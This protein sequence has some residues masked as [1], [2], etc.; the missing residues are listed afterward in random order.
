MSKRNRR[1]VKAA[2][3]KEREA[4]PLAEFRAIR[5]GACVCC[6]DYTHTY[7]PLRWCSRCLLEAS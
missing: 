1:E 6:G 3:R 2:R 4:K 5:Y 7:E